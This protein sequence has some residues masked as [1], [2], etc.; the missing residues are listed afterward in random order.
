MKYL[1][2][3]ILALSCFYLAISDEPRQEVLALAGSQ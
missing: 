2:I 3:P 1:I